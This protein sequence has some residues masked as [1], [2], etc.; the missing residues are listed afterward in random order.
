MRVTLDLKD[1]SK[2]NFPMVVDPMWG[3]ANHSDWIEGGN[4]G[5]SPNSGAMTLTEASAVKNSSFMKST[6]FSL[7]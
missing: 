1:L 2:V 4:S 5:L 7:R 6:G 3:E